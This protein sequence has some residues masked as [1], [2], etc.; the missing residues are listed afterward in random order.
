MDGNRKELK[1]KTIRFAYEFDKEGRRRKVDIFPSS[2]AFKTEPRAS[3]PICGA[4][5][6]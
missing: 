1:E 3:Y 5:E 2:L 6:K 4:S